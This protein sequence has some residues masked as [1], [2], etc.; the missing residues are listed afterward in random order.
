MAQRAQF[1]D[2]VFIRWPS[3]GLSVPPTPA[4]VQAA[5]YDVGTINPI[6]EP[7]YAAESGP[8]LLPNPLPADNSGTILF[9]L[10]NER[11]LDVVITCP[12][13]STVRHTISTDSA[14]AA[15]DSAVRTYVGHIMGVIDPGGAPAPAP[16]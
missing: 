15:I 10:Q 2:T 7:I 9:W 14:G 1:R 6:S 5:L 13:Y 8:D 11:M 4:G 3:G 16:P 12:G